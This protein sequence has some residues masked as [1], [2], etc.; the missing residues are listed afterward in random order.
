M[1]GEAR[2]GEEEDWNEYENTAFYYFGNMH[3]HCAPTWSLWAN[4]YISYIF[5]VACS[6]EIFFPLL[7]FPLVVLDQILCRT[8]HIWTRTLAFSQLPVKLLTPSRWECRWICQLTRTLRLVCLK[9][10]ATLL[11]FPLL[12]FCRHKQITI[13]SLSF[14]NKLGLYFWKSF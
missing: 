1:S 13:N 10:Q 14:E 12:Q 4:L 2:S 3:I 9:E 11:Q 8:P 6:D 5:S 7:F